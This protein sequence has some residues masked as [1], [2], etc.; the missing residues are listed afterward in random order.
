MCYRPPRCTHTQYSY[1]APH[2]RFL[3]K[4]GKTNVTKSNPSQVRHLPSP[5]MPY[6]L[7]SPN[8]GR[9]CQSSARHRYV[10][11]QTTI[12]QALYWTSERKGKGF[13]TSTSLPSLNFNTSIIRKINQSVKNYFSTGY[14]I[15]TLSLPDNQSAFS[16]RRSLYSAGVSFSSSAIT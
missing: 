11:N 2:I 6:A 14:G 12:P 7:Y 1:T 3:E 4:R 5:S 13:I 15:P 8:R 16:L 10:R 9:L